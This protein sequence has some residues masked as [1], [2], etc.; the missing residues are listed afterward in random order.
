MRRGQPSILCVALTLAVVMAGCGSDP[1]SPRE[2]EDVN[3]HPSTGVNLA[4]MTKTDSGLYYQVLVE[5]TGTDVAAPPDLVTFEYTFWLSNGELFE[6]EAIATTN[7]GGG[8]VQPM[9]EGVDEGL[10]G[11]RVGDTRLLVIPY[12]LGYGAEP[13]RGLPAYAT[14]VFKVTVVVIEH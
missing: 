1:V 12:Y 2:P 9:I 11:M 6:N 5:G 10:T 13:Y 7:L 3:F 4:L 8:G 14:L